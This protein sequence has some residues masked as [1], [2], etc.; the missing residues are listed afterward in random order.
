MITC[1]K[2]KNKQIKT[3]CHLQWYNVNMRKYSGEWLILMGRE[4]ERKSNEIKETHRG[5]FKRI[6]NILYTEKHN[7]E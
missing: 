2:F 5:I 6:Q 4:G 3:I 1:V 7:L